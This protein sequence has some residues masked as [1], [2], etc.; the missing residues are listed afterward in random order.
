MK[1]EMPYLY[2]LS[3]TV[4]L[5]YPSMAICSLAT[6]LTRAMTLLYF[7]GNLAICILA[8]SSSY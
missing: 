8:N 2:L 3:L 7:E 6:I 1:L 4:I 5:V